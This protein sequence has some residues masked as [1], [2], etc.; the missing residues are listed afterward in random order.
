MKF[1]IIANKPLDLTLSTY[2]VQRQ[3]TF[4]WWKYWKD[5]SNWLH[6]AKACEDFIQVYLNPESKIIKEIK[7]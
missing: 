7:V 3:H 2:K 1:R 5:V 6:S 4:L